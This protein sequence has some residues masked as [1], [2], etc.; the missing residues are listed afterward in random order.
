MPTYR[1]TDPNTGRTLRLTGDSP[2]TEQELEE[3]FA[4]AEPK[5]IRKVAA[6]QGIAAQPQQQTG[7]AEGVSAGQAALIGTGRGMTTIGRAVGLAEPEEP[8]VTDAVEELREAHPVAV[9]GGEIAGESAP[10]LLP[11]LGTAAIPSTAARVAATTALGAAEGGLISRGQGQDAENQ[12]ITAGVAGAVA[13]GLELA[14]PHVGR[15]GGKVIRKVF[16]RPPKGAVVDAAGKPSAELVAALDELGLDFDDIV[17]P[18]GAVDPSQ[19]ARKALMESE[20]LTPT[21]AQITRDAGDFQAQQEAAKTSGRV[22]TALERQEATL[23]TRFNQAV[24]ETGGD[25]VAPE[26]TVVN[27]LTEK[28]SVLDKE[29]SRLYKEAREFAPAEK[30]VRLDGLATK[31]KEMAG[32]DRASGGVIDAVVGDLKAKGVLDDALKVRGRIDVETAEDVRKLMNELFDPKG[33][34]GN[35]VIR[36][37]KDS[38]DDDVFG[39]AGQDVFAAGRSAKAS[40][41]KE[42][43]R[44]K[45]SKFDSRKANLVRDVL[46]N[47]IDPDQLVEK[48]VFGKS[49][50]PA[51]L[52]QLKDYV[53]TTDAGK[54]AWNDLRAEVMESIKTKSFIGP[55]DNEGFQALSFD[56][57][58]KAIKSI[59]DKRMNILFTPKERQFLSRMQKISQ[60]RQPVRGTALG[61]GPTGAAVN[62]LRAELRKGSIVANLA[63]TVSFDSKGRAALRAA[64]QA[65]KK[66]VRGSAGRLAIT[67][68]AAA[69]TAAGE[70]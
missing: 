39:A 20:G 43:A 14:L 2:P 9:T 48:V 60:L 49:W 18:S 26:S 41:E 56:K 34:Y 42:L 67:A 40:F 24:A 68:P 37:L 38:L 66:P 61:D 13:G 30:V 33:G 8:I 3:V 4:A 57:L 69:A 16:G 17:P 23:T 22:R 10:F 47:R 19:A 53:T 35:S 6:D 50:R 11:G 44:A 58:N 65:I 12:A 52:S 55:V 28:A 46:E 5:G 63:D 32:A 25:A 54:A 1:V 62:K 51:D 36:Q 15:V 29:I 21:T 31:L 70:Q 27:A 45:I 59:G 64:P 7:A